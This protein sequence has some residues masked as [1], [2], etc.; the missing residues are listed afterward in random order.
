MS[1]IVERLRRYCV[2]P[3]GTEAADR[4]EQLEAALKEFTGIKPVR[5]RIAE[6][7][8]ALQELISAMDSEQ[9]TL[10]AYDKAR[11]VLHP[12]PLRVGD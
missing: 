12:H 6:L 2:E 4:I 8:A 11:A 5:I 3:L 7:E 9:A 10:E 1:D